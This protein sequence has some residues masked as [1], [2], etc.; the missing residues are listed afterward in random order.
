LRDGYRIVTT[1]SGA[2]VM[3]VRTGGS[4]ELSSEEVLLFARATAG[5]V[6]SKDPQLRNV[7]KKFVTL[8][9]LVSNEPQ[10]SDARSPAGRPP[11]LGGEVA[12]SSSTSGPRPPSVS[13]QVPASP[14][15]FPAPPASAA[16]SPAPGPSAASSHAASSIESALSSAGFASPSI[17]PTGLAPPAPAPPSMRSTEIAPMKEV[18]PSQNPQAAVAPGRPK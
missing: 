10:K 18:R 3:H 4:I 14:S 1:P 15:F 16:P 13:P 8:G 11:S 7:I 17:S 2:R 12:A 5:G 9:V 6:D